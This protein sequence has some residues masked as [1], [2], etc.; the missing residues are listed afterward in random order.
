MWAALNR[1]EGWN[2]VYLAAAEISSTKT[3]LGLKRHIFKVPGVPKYI[4]YSLPAELARHM[5]GV[6]FQLSEKEPLACD[7]PAPLA[8]C[9]LFTE[10]PRPVPTCRAWSAS[11][12]LQL[13]SICLPLLLRLVIRPLYKSPDLA[14]ADFQLLSVISKQQ[15]RLR[16]RC[17]ACHYVRKRKMGW[18]RRRCFES[19]STRVCTGST[20]QK[21]LPFRLWAAGVYDAERKGLAGGDA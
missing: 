16:S 6:L 3:A 1:L 10:N 2:A 21:I 8:G 9:R 17:A 5:Q 20:T 15:H 11:V 19:Q 14:Y 18:R 13:K 7:V 12:A 4:A